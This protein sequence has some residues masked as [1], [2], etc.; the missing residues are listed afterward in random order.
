MN[1]QGAPKKGSSQ[2][3]VGYGGKNELLINTGSTTIKGFLPHDGV[4][5]PSDVRDGS[6]PGIRPG[7]LLLGSLGTCIAGMMALYA[8]NHG[9]SLDA[10]SVTLTDVMAENPS[11]IGGIDVTVLIT[12]NLSAE[13]V[14]KLQKVAAACKVSDSLKHPMRISVSFEPAKA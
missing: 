9:Y 10:A 3:V 7:E 8:R 14:G 2:V 12:G 1:E 4:A 11:R 6:E 5:S 13:Q